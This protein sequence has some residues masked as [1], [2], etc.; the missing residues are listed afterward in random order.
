MPN[1]Q[2]LHLSHF[3]V[4][5]SVG[6]G[7]DATLLSLQTGSSG[8]RPCRFET[9]YLPTYVGEV[10]GLAETR[11]PAA[12]AS[13]DCRNNRLAEMAL[14]QDGFQ[15]AVASIVARYGPRRIGLF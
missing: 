3:S 6:A 8:L 5:S 10:P 2:P 1:M 14:R 4:I 15:D 11:L 9:V 13:F 7:L 12:L